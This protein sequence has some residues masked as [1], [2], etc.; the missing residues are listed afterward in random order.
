MKYKFYLHFCNF[1]VFDYKPEHFFFNLNN[2]RYNLL[3]LLVQNCVTKVWFLYIISF[4]YTIIGKY[5]FVHN[6]TILKYVYIYSR[7][8]VVNTIKQTE[9]YSILYK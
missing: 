3:I 9:Q 8:A 7:R 2:K 6:T 1:S 4:Q 5:I